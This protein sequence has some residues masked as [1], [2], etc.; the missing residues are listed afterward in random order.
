MSLPNWHWMLSKPQYTLALGLG[1][2]LSPKA[3]GTV[4]SLLGFPL[5][6]LLSGLNIT[7]VLPFMI[8]ALFILGIPLCHTTGKALGESDHSAIVWDE[9]VAMAW[10]LSMAP[11]SLTWQMAAFALFRFFDIVKPWP[12]RYVDR[13]I[14][15]GFGVMLDDLLAAGFSI[16]ILW[17]ATSLTQDQVIF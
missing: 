1:A 3:P 17:L 9:I 7:G 2:G 12:I 4:G 15:N 10:V 14:K 13:T 16:V 5:Y 6:Y 8:L 11:H